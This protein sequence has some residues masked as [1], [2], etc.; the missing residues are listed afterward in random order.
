MARHRRGE[1]HR[2]S[3]PPGARDLSRHSRPG[4]AL[5]MVAASTIPI[6]Q[7]SAEL[8]GFYVPQFEVRIE[9]SALPRSILRDVVE[10]TYNDKLDEIDSAELV[11]NNWDADAF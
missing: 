8:L 6:S 9:G 1:R 11:V 3:P 5:I 7:A 4:R 2:R 10:V